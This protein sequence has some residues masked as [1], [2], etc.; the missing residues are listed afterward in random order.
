M[1]QPIKIKTKIR[2]RDFSPSHHA[3]L[4]KE[5]TRE[6]TTRL[7]ARIGELQQLLYANAAASVVI[8]LQGMDTSGKEIGRAHV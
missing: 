4:D 3:G 6:K 8:L 7:C 5:A 2:L 1:S